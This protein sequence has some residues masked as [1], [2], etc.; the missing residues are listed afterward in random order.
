[1]SDISGNLE[2]EMAELTEK[3]LDD[4]LPV[5]AALYEVL[6][7]QRPAVAVAAAARALASI[8]LLANIG[9][10]A[11]LVLYRADYKNLERQ[12]AERM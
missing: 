12:L 4:A 7:R 11:A 9:P 2:G 5:A 10:D 3:D 8:A 6:V 1:M